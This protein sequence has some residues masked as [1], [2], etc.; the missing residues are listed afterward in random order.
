M[1]CIVL[2]MMLFSYREWRWCLSFKKWNTLGYH[3]PPSVETG[4]S[5]CFSNRR[6]RKRTS[7]T[8]MFLSLDML[9]ERI[10]LLAGTSIATQCHTIS[11]PIMSNDSS[12][13]NPSTFLFLEDNFLGLYF[14]IQFQMEIWFRLIKHDYSLSQALLKKSPE[15][16]Y[17]S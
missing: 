8:N 14:C 5:P 12:T 4:C 9:V 2:S 17:K 1:Y 10:S 6:Y 16:K 3:V 7:T 13:T 11:K 15:K